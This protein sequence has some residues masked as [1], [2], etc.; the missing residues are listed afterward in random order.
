MIRYGNLRSGISCRTL[1]LA[2]SIHSIFSRSGSACSCNPL[3]ARYSQLWGQRLLCFSLSGLPSL[4]FFLPQITQDCGSRCIGILPH[5]FLLPWNSHSKVSDIVFFYNCTNTFWMRL[6][7]SL[8][9]PFVQSRPSWINVSCA[10]WLVHCFNPGILWNPSAHY[11]H[12]THFQS[13]LGA[14]RTDCC[15]LLRFPLHHRKF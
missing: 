12:P 8:A 13:Q 2:G 6:C 3:S 7:L 11:F 15:P 4:G 10:G 14:G 9:L 1:I 5:R